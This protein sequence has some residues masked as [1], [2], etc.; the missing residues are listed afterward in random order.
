MIER[1]IGCRGDEGHR[2][3]ASYPTMVRRTTTAESTG[4]RF[5]ARFAVPARDITK[6][7]AEAGALSAAGFANRK[8]IFHA[9][10][11]ALP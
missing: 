6:A 5:L 11:P 3:G 2:E 10:F 9:R 8:G 7:P 1:L 4:A